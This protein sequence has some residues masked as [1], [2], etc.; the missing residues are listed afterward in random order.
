MI[1]AMEGGKKE[2][3]RGKK[4]ELFLKNNSLSFEVP[5][6]RDIVFCACR[7]FSSKIFDA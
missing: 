5:G 3:I 2:G 4:R 1:Q 6:V 7:P